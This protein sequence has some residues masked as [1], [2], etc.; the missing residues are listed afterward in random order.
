ML[1]AQCE[2]DAH[3]GTLF[4]V[5]EAVRAVHVHSRTHPRG[6]AGSREDRRWAGWAHPTRWLPFIPCL[7][8]T[9]SREPRS[10]RSTSKRPRRV[11]RTSD[12]PGPSPNR[13]DQLLR[14]HVSEI[15]IGGRE[16][17]VAELR[18]DE[19]GWEP[20]GCQLGCVGV[21]EAVRVDALLDSGLAGETGQ[22]S[23]HV[24]VLEGS[25]AE[26]TEHA[27]TT[28]EPQ[29]PPPVKPAFREREAAGVETDGAAP[30]ALAVE[31][32]RGS[33]PQI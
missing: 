23:A 14:S 11:R 33:R 13:V 25:S 21:A 27:L 15:P 6:D 24:G 16:A 26:R 30:V 28:V 19:I 22:E 10:Q 8:A 7:E 17:R 3:A 2:A 9:R 20:L 4:G 12:V 32:D 18:L 1:A 31:R 29:L 5:G